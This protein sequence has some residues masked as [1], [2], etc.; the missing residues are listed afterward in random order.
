MNNKNIISTFGTSSNASTPAMESARSNPSTTPV[1]LVSCSTPLQSRTYA[2]YRP[3]QAP[4]QRVLVDI[5]PGRRF[6]LP[7]SPIPEA[8]SSESTRYVFFSRHNFQGSFPLL[9]CTTEF[10]MFIHTQ[11]EERLQQLSTSEIMW[12]N[13]HCFCPEMEEQLA[14]FMDWYVVIPTYRNENSIFANHLEV[15]SMVTG[16]VHDDGE[17]FSQC[18]QREL[19]EE[20]GLTVES[21]E[22]IFQLDWTHNT[23]R[24]YICTLTDVAPTPLPEPAVKPE[25]DR[26]KT[27]ACIPLVR[28]P[29]QVLR[30]NRISSADAD[31]A[32]VAVAVIH[33]QHYIPILHGL[34]RRTPP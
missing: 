22:P 6:A 31:I 15:Q 13:H 26:S 18:C 23:T 4:P 10:P 14:H 16:G 5:R 32:G 1:P 30:R 19:F 25:D 33:V 24:F 27:I 29:N 7:R 2:A 17:R 20:I 21:G 9:A 11:G 34:N 28:D 3:R 12:S 8:S